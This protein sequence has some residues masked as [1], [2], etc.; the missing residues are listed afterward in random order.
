MAGAHE[1]LEHAEHAAHGGHGHG[2]HGKAGGLGTYIGLT[3]GIIGVLL[4]IAAAKVGGERTELVQSMVERESTNARYQA[5]DIKHRMAYLTLAQ[6]HAS[7]P[8]IPD[9]PAGAAVKKDVVDM[10]RTVRRYFNEAALAKKWLD[11]YEPAIKAHIEAQEEYEKGQLLAEVGIVL[12][13]IALLLQ[14]KAPWFIAIALGVASVA[15]IGGTYVHTKHEVEEAEEKIGEARKVYREARQ[16][17]KTTEA[18]ELV[19]ADVMK[20]AGVDPGA[21]SPPGAEP[22]HESD[23][24]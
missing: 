4:A 21:A 15:V 11:S 1:A 22:E 6:T 5:Q 19:I 7:P 2:G 16:A 9:G 20:W 13:S 23:H 3:M 12:A 8:T 17:D 10:A 18:E 24:E 14:R